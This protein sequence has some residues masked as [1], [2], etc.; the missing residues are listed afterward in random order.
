MALLAHI[1]NAPRSDAMATVTRLDPDT[2]WAAFMRRDR[3]W[4][5]RL[6]GAVHTTGIYCKPSCPARRPKRENVAFYEVDRGG[7]GGG[8]P[9]VSSLQARR[10]RPRPRGGGFGGRRHRAVGRGS[11]FFPSWPTPSATRPTISSASSSATSASLRR[12]MR[13]LCAIAEPRRRSRTM[14]GSPMQSMTPAITAR[15]DST[16]MRRRGWA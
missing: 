16:A 4:D 14:S 7:E 5:G 8:L 15:A 10:G 13:A 1:T 9:T 11:E 3:S 6:F 12:N 2:A